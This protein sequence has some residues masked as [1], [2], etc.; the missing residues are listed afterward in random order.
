MTKTGGSKHLKRPSAPSTWPINRKGSKFLPK[1][2]PG[3]HGTNQGLPLIVLLRDV[4]KVGTTRKEITYLL[5]N[6]NVL[7]DGKVRTNEKFPVGHMDIVEIKKLNKFYRVQYHS[8][9]KLLP[10]EI[11]ENEANTKIVKIIGKKSIR[12]G[13]TQVSLHDG[14]NI[15][16]LNEDNRLNEIK[17]N[18][19]LQIEVPSQEIQS[20][21]HLEEDSWAMVTEGRHQGKVG[22]IVEIVKRFGP[23]ASEVTFNDPE[24]KEDP[25]FKTALDYVF[26]IGDVAPKVNLQT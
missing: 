2:N 26:V 10:F 4:L 11:G 9:G 25:E 19:S 1:M 3:P 12:G 16:L 8:S 21:F 14:R 23:K 6:K 15:R 7:V 24:N 17:V 5:T 20:I 18:G 13:Y 22:Q